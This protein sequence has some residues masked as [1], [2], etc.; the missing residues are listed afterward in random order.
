[1]TEVTPAP[2]AGTETK[3]GGGKVATNNAL[4]A[5]H[6]NSFRISAVADRLAIHVRAAP[7]NDTVE[8]FNLCLSLARGI[9]FSISNEEVPSRAKDLPSLLKQVC[10]CKN[11]AVVQAAVMVLMISVKSACESGW[12]S[13]RDSEELQNLA[14]EIACNFCSVSNFNTEPTSSLSCYLNNHVEVKY[15]VTCFDRYSVVPT[16]KR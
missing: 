12:F 9:D 1:M 14:K 16:Y 4:N 8:F 5:S 15:Y 3:G 7:K 2:M 13:E 11:D 6:V 10:Q